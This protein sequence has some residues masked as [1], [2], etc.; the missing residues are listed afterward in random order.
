MS[1]PRN[2]HEGLQESCLGVSGFCLN[3][4]QT[5]YLLLYAWIWIDGS[6]HIWPSIWY[7]NSEQCLS[8]LWKKT[9]HHS[10]CLC[11]IRQ[12]PT[13]LCSIS[14]RWAKQMIVS[15]ACLPLNSTVPVSTVDL[16]KQ[17]LHPEPSNH[18]SLLFW[19]NEGSGG[20]EASQCGGSFHHCPL[21]QTSWRLDS[22]WALQTQVCVIKKGEVRTWS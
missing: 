12:P 11:E 16:A 5:L 17:Y 9:E 20:L 8:S 15:S 18:S 7:K 2:L 10:E 19:R 3:P 1:R 14:M 22:K 21:L 13:L 6:S 4:R